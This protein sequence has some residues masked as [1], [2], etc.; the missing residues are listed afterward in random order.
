[1]YAFSSSEAVERNC[2][3]T[4]DLIKT[5]YSESPAIVSS[6][7]GA[8]ID[9]NYYAVHFLRE[10]RDEEAL[11][12]FESG[13]TT[14]GIGIRHV[15][16]ESLV[17]FLPRLKSASKTA[18]PAPPHKADS[19]SEHSSFLHTV[20][21]SQEHTESTTPIIR[22]NNTFEVFESA[23][24]F[25]EHLPIMEEEHSAVLLAQHIAPVLLFNLGLLVHKRAATSADY[26]LAHELYRMSLFLMEENTIKGLY[27]KSF[28]LLLL[29][30][31]NNLCELNCS[32][33]QKDRVALCREK[34]INVFHNLERRQI[35]QEDYAFF[36][37]TIGA[38]SGPLSHGCRS[39]MMKA[40]TF[41]CRVFALR[42]LAGHPHPNR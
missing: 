19:S 5:K 11:F 42:T 12:L 25:G 36:P 18:T 7:I 27:C 40:P 26:F 32:F 13:L 3:L 22:E 17:A 31:F 9:M 39:C 24:L 15:F 28:D 38:F 21:I 35:R 33:Y 6:M 34:F 29:A 23:V 16:G 20:N 8:L 37:R 41:L 10:N 4:L 14:C 30:L 1:M 2:S